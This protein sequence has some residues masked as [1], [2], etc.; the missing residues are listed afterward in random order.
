MPEHLSSGVASKDTFSRGR[1]VALL[2]AGRLA[3]GLKRLFGSN[4]TRRILFLN[5]AGLVALVGGIL[6]VNS[7]RASL[8]EARL[9]SLS[10]Q[11]QIIAAAIASAAVVE[12][13]G[14]VIDPLKL[15]DLPLGESYR[16]SSE[17]D[18]FEFLLNP[19]RI[20]PVLRALVLPTQTRARVYDRETSLLLDSQMLYT[21]G[22]IVS[23]QLPPLDEDWSLSFSD[24]AKRFLSGPKAPLVDETA[25]ATQG[26]PNVRLA[27]EGNIVSFVASNAQG[28]LKAMVAVP[29]SRFREVMGVV[30][31]STEGNDIE[32]ALL[33]ERLAILRVAGVAMVV[34]TLLSLYLAR[35]IAGP[36]RQ[37][38]EAAEQTQKRVQ[39]R[40][41]IPDFS[42]RGDEIGHLSRSLTGMTSALYERIESIERFAA[43]VAH[44]LK[45]PL[46][47]LRS[48]IDTLPLVKSDDQKAK[49]NTVI[50]HDIKRLNRLI[51]DIAEASRLDAELQRHDMTQIDLRA[52]LSTLV[53]IAQGVHG[54]HGVRVVFECATEQRIMT[55]GHD[56]RLAQVITNLV[57][58]A[59]SF[60]PE[61]GVIRVH[62]AQQGPW[63]LIRVED[64]GPGIKAD[65][66]ERIF[67]RFYTDRPVETFGNNS[68][69]GLSICRQI[70]EAFGGSIKASNRL[71]GSSVKGAVFV[72]QL[73]LAL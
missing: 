19:E 30:L 53:D 27:A 60:S 73:P 49:L 55:R 43:D 1:F 46:T 71:E 45:N 4:L 18:D 40:V 50:Q 54:S 23:A 20:G 10:T 16:H 56:G 17:R 15:Q 69:L 48:A 33:N 21:R 44:E 42:R 36:V 28:E 62:L 32:K 51:T 11:G 9:E 14:V 37:L 8:I 66:F 38:S 68:G 25:L 58:N 13:E 72:I 52:L 34:M 47:S 70:V 6:S 26:H 39:T 67:E 3:R 64:E 2:R 63:A 57:D 31:L 35:T 65:A 41:H 24:L 7:Q 59:R 61:G 5:L 22:A 12:S 29:I